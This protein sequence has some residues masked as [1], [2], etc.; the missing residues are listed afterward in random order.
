M[1]TELESLSDALTGMSDEDKNTVILAVQ[2]E[3]S[4]NWRVPPMMQMTIPGTEGFGF[5]SSIPSILKGDDN[6]LN[7]DIVD[8]MMASGQ[9]AYPM[10]LKKAPIA[11]IVRSPSGFSVEC[12]DER[13]KGLILKN[14]QRVLE[15]RIDE[16]LT[17]LEYGAYYGEVTYHIGYPQDYGLPKSTVPYWIIDDFNGCHPTTI[18]RILRDEKTRAFRGFVQTPPGQVRIDPITVTLERALIIPHN[19]LFGKLEGSSIL[20]PVHVWWFWY[21][22]VW[23]AFLRYLQRQGVGVVV[24]K[25]P[26]RGRVEINGRY[27]DNMQWALQMAS[28]LHRTNYAALPSDSDSDSGKELWSIDYLKIGQDEGRQF[29]AALEMLSTNIKNFLLTGSN[30]SEEGG[31]F[32]VMLDTEKTLAHIAMY[33]NN[34]VLPRFLMW[35]GSKTRIATLSFQGAN[36]RVLPLI[37]KLLAVAGNTTGDALQNV[38]WRL[39]MAEGGVPVLPE[40]EV[41]ELREKK[42]EEFERMRGGSEER[43]KMPPGGEGRWA[44]QRDKEGRAESLE[45]IAEALNTPLIALTAPQVAAMERLGVRA[46]DSPILLF[47]PYHDRAGKF[48]DKMHATKPLPEGKL[49]AH[50]VNERSE[51]LISD[52]TSLAYERVKQVP[53]TVLAYGKK[54]DYV[55]ALCATYPARHKV[56]CVRRSPRA[57]AIYRDGKTY[58]SPRGVK[59]ITKDR[60]YGEY[61]L[62]HEAFHSRRRSDGQ[63]G[64][65]VSFDKVGVVKRDPSYHRAMARY[66]LEEGATD[67]LAR[68]LHGVDH[69]YTADSFF[70]GAPAYMK[71]MGAIA[72]LAGIASDWDKAEAW[73]LINLM[74][75]NINDD[76]YVFD[77]LSQAFGTPAEGWDGSSYYALLMSL[78]KTAKDGNF[79]E[80]GWLFGDME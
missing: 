21:E 31:E 26:S 7:Y 2:E 9:I 3:I 70:S 44:S 41:E 18:D 75:Y 68:Q 8:K 71:Q 46:D 36:S 57:Y 11:S 1:L 30:V 45:M 38:D 6:T 32:E 33:I 19:G 27:V 55:N 53:R 63:D 35:N 15:K 28:S 47:N 37:F 58:V 51:F 60:K 14:M 48:T 17:M 42:F 5:V 54:N 40:D 65:D 34:Y 20:Q 66:H 79:A 64:V 56:A 76:G 22:L 52:A 23:R 4:A 29:V 39:L 59:A 73:R 50:G 61:I 24:V 25:A 67:L 72:I 12:S 16:I 78:Q 13:M 74:H 49:R 43:A 77:L 69:N 80:L 10:A 62:T